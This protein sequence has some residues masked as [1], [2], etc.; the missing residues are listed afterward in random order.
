MT[1]DRVP[2]QGNADH[3]QITA[4]HRLVD[5]LVD[6]AIDGGDDDAATVATVTRPT[7]GTETEMATRVPLLV[8]APTLQDLK[9]RSHAAWVSDCMNGR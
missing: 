5:R 9:R 7:V 8:S 2:P 4:F 1:S 3:A 6:G